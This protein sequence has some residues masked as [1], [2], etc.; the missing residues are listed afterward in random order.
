MRRSPPSGGSRD[1]WIVRV[2]ASSAN[3]GSAFD[4][5]A[6]ALDVHLEVTTD[7][8]DPAPE[9]H[10]AVRAFRQGG[11]VGPIAVRARFPGGRGLGFSGAARVGGL[12]AACVQRGGS[13]REARPEILRAAGDLDGHADNAAASLFGGVVAVA[14]GHAVRIPLPHDLV[15]VVWT[16]DRETST[17]SARRL[18]PE[19]VP[20]EDAAFNIG[21]TAL[22][23]A[24]LAAGDVGALRIATEDRLHQGRRLA[25]AHD[26]R[27]AID[28]ALAA[29]AFAAWLSGSGPTAAAL[30][31]PSCAR[32]IAAALPAGGR[33]RVLA[34]A[35]V[36]ATVTTREE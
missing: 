31:E 32:E 3:L 17:P 26:T 27:Q 33:A 16:P 9:T 8:D 11:G 36:G 13:L 10:P 12:V 15:V 14:G 7:A 23:V 18:L 30:A 1:D 25:R 34:I 24:A 21:R 35:E 22:L 4:A 28:A 2:P 5:V 29:G 6:V 20:F 19:Q